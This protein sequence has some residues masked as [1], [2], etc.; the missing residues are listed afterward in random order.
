MKKLLI[1]GALMSLAAFTPA[2]FAKENAG[3]LEI[4]KKTE[5]EIVAPAT[6]VDKKMIKDLQNIPGLQLHFPPECFNGGSTLFHS[7]T[8]EMRFKCLKNAIYSSSNNVIWALR[9]GYGSAKL[10]SELAKL[11]KPATEKLFIGYSD[12]TA[13]HIFFSQ[14]W[15]WKPIHG[16]MAKELLDDD[17]KRD[18]FNKL[19]EI[20]AGK[21]GEVKISGLKGLNSKA[22]SE[23]KVTGLLTGGNLTMIQTSIGTIWQIDTKNKIL[24]LEDRGIAPYQV[25]RTLLHLKQ[26][27]LLKEVSAIIFG[28]FGG[29][30]NMIKLLEDFAASQNI[31]IYMSDHFGHGKINDPLIYNVKAT[32]K[33]A[34]DGTYDL[35]MQIK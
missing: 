11:P 5:I 24:F 35:I 17:K 18:N 21:V 16:A 32:L 10:I 12:M 3:F 2:K 8:D 9:G 33:L 13:L 31:P 6:G 14:V 25:D 30:D 23:A 26:A 19:A 4:L 22:K 7:H 34:K 29:G 15:G 20:I 1:I 27:G 28:D